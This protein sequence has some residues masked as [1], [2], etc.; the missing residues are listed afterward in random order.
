MK[1][2][3]LTVTIGPG[4]LSPPSVNKQLTLTPYYR[5]PGYWRASSVDMVL[6]TGSHVDF[7]AHVVKGGEI[8]ADVA[9]DRF[10]GD[11]LV[12]DLHGLAADEPI[13]VEAVQRN[14][15]EVGAGDIV[16]VRLF[17]WLLRTVMSWKSAA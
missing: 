13:T 15:A 1:I 3:D 6:H 10:C 16:L 5:G 4:T 14:G 11:A 9:L 8:A 7:S 12:V 2:V 17:T